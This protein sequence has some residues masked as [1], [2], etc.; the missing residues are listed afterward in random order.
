MR[1]LLVLH[2]IFILICAVV[3]AA[4]DIFKRET[5]LFCLLLRNRCTDNLLVPFKVTVAIMT[6][7]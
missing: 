3:H 5:I 4:L 1:F 7:L 6:Q 2:G